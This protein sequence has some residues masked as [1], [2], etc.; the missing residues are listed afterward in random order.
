MSLRK[1]SHSALHG[2]NDARMKH[3]LQGHFLLRTASPWCSAGYRSSFKKWPLVSTSAPEGWRS[4]DS[5]VPCCKVL[6]LITTEFT[7]F[8]GEYENSRASSIYFGRMYVCLLERGNEMFVYCLSNFCT[9]FYCILNIYVILIWTFCSF[10]IDILKNSFVLVKCLSSIGV[11][12]WTWVKEL[13]KR[14]TEVSTFV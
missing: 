13:L 8:S 7:C 1:W 4:W 14:E 10:V 12:N 3:W 5:C 11:W 2:W 6:S 9:I